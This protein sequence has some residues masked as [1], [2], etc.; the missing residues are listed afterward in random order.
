MELN[1]N[2][3]TNYFN[4][5]MQHHQ[6]G[7]SGV[8]LIDNKFQEPFTSMID[9]K[10]CTHI[11]ETEVSME[12]NA[13]N[14]NQESKSIKSNDHKLHQSKLSGWVPAELKRPQWT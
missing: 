6:N 4:G 11:R 8:A 14:G 9:G 13:H 12:K 3:P 7:N 5:A 2:A 10:R 1:D